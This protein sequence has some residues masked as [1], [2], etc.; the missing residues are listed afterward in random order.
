MVVVS[1]SCLTSSVV[2]FIM[3]GVFLL[4]DEL[5]FCLCVFLAH[6]FPVILLVFALPL[7]VIIHL[8]YCC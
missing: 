7:G 8:E 5:Y 2:V 3:P 4:F 1:I 6:R